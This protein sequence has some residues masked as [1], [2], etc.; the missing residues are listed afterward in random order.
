MKQEIDAQKRGERN[1]KL[2]DGGHH[3]GGFVL[4]L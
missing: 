4:Q 2:A 1:Q 3:K